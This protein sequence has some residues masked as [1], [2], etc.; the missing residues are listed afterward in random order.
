MSNNDE[1][2]FENDLLPEKVDLQDYYIFP[3]NLAWT[4]AFTHGDGCLGPYFAEHRNYNKLNN[5]NIAEIEKRRKK[6]K[7]IE[8]AKNKGWM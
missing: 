3:R 6:Q 2:A 7:E 4:M 8:I 5:Q 1:P